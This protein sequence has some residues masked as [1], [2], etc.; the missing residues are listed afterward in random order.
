[1]SGSCPHCKKD[2]ELDSLM[3]E[4]RHMEYGDGKEFDC[5]HC[6]NVIY[7]INY[8]GEYKISSKPFTDPSAKS[9]TIGYA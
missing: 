2:L 9:E 8:I 6:K 5:P 1:M 3:S 4:L 7:S